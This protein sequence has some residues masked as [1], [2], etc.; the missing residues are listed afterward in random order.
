MH[1][2]RRCHPRLQEP[3]SE[4]PLEVCALDASLG[5]P[6]CCPV[7]L[8]SPE[9]L[10]QSWGRTLRAQGSLSLAGEVAQLL[11]IPRRL[12]SPPFPDPTGTGQQLS[13]TGTSLKTPPYGGYLLGHLTVP[14]SLLPLLLHKLCAL[15]PSF[16]IHFWANREEAEGIQT[17]NDTTLTGWNKPE[18]QGSVILQYTVAG[19]GL[20]SIQKETV[21]GN[22]CVQKPWKTYRGTEQRKS[23]GIETRKV[24]RETARRNRKCS[25]PCMCPSLRQSLP[26]FDK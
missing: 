4:R 19:V 24:K 2:S 20:R 18:S 13:T 10:L 12:C 22:Q 1:H 7:C 25:C 8:S 23:P 26:W 9:G 16:H 14:S 5:S 3:E 21:S 15:E 11:T 17:P 6:S